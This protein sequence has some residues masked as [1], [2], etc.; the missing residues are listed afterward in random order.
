MELN[1][2]P[3]EEHKEF[4]PLLVPLLGFMKV[5]STSSGSSLFWRVWMRLVVALALLVE[6]LGEGGCIAL[7]ASHPLAAQA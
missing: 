6:P 2:A 1:L 3:E 4:L 7:A 5:Y